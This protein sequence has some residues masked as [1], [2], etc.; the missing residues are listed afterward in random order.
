MRIEHWELSIG[1]I[2]P[3]LS[4]VKLFL[5]KPLAWNASTEPLQDLRACENISDRRSS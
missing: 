1:Q 3:Y 5:G 2:F 4:S